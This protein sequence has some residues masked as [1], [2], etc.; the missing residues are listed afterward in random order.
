MSN[1]YVKKYDVGQIKLDLPYANYIHELPLLSFGDILHTINLSLVFNY[2]NRGENTFSVFKGYKFNWQK[3]IILDSSTQRPTSFVDEYGKTTNLY[4]NDG[5]YTF[6]DDSQRIIRTT[7]RPSLPPIPGSD[8]EMEDGIETFDYTVEYPDGSKEVYNQNGY[9]MS[10]CDKYSDN[11]FLTFLHLSNGRLS[12]IIYN[13]NKKIIFTYPDDSEITITYKVGSESICTTTINASDNDSSVLVD[14]YSGARYSISLSN[15]TYEVFSGD[16]NLEF[17]TNFSKKWVCTK[18]DNIL[19]IEKVVGNETVDSNEYC[20]V[21]N[22]GERKE[23]NLIDVTDKYNKTTRIQLIDGKPAYS[24]EYIDDFLNNEAYGESVYTGTVSSYSNTEII[25][26]QCENEGFSLH[27]MSEYSWNAPTGSLEGLSGVFILSGWINVASAENLEMTVEIEHSSSITTE[28]KRNIPVLEDQ[29][30]QYFSFPFEASNIRSLSVTSNPEWPTLY[31]KDVRLTFISGRIVGDDSIDYITRVEDVFIVEGVQEEVLPVSKCR[32]Y[33]GNT[34]IDGQVTKEDILRYKINQAYG[35]R[36]N[37]IY[38]NGCKN[39]I[40]DS[41]AF[42]M[43]YTND[44]VIQEAFVTNVA[45]GERCYKN[46]KIYLTKTN[47]YASDNTS[48]LMT[49]SYKD[50]ICYKTDIYSE[51]LDLISSKVDNI[52][53]TYSR[54]SKGL[55]CTQTVSA[56]GSTETI[57]TSASYNS[58]CTKLLSTTDEF[59]AT[60]TYEMDDIWG[61]ITKIIPDEDHCITNE[62]DLNGIALI[63]RT[64]ATGDGARNNSLGYSNGRLSSLA[65]GLLDYSF[66]YSD[67]HELQSII[68]DGQTIQTQSITENEEGSTLNVQYPSS[69]SETQTFDKYG[70]LTSIDGALNNTYDIAPTYNT[71]TNT[72]TTAGKDNIR[73]KLASTEDLTGSRFLRRTTKYAYE[74]N[75]LSRVGTFVT[76][77][78]IKEEIFTYDNADRMISDE[79]N[80]DKLGNKS[81]SSE[82]TY[83]TDQYS[84][85]VDNRVS[86]YKYKVNGVVKAQTENTYNPFKRIS[87]K[88]YW[89]NSSKYG[90]IYTFSGSR[91]S[92]ILD[93]F[94]DSSV[95]RPIGDISYEYDSIGR[96]S[97]INDNDYITNYTYDEYGQLIKEES[98]D[99]V[100]EY[101]YNGIG[102]IV[103]ATENGTATTFSYSNIYPDR[104]TEYGLSDITYNSSGYPTV[105]GSK[106]FDWSKGKLVKYYDE[107]DP[108]GSISSESTEFTYNGFGQRTSK[109]YT[110]N[111]GAD[112]SGD[113][114]TGKETKYEYDHS[115][116]LIR[117]ITTEYF[118]ESATQTR[119]FIFLYDESGMIG[120]MYSFNNS[121]PQAYYYQRNLLG[122]VIAIYNTSGNKVVEYAYD[123]YGNCTVTNSTNYALS[124]Y[125]PI[126]YRGY[127][128]DT[129]TGWYYLNARYYSP[130]WCRFISPDDTSYL[131]P[132]YVN[133]LNLYCYCGNDPVNYKQRHISSRGSATSSSISVGGSTGIGGSSGGSDSISNGSA[134]WYAQTIVGALP[135]LYSGARYLMTKGM[136]KY[137]A[138]KKNY[139]YMFPILGETH[140]RLAIH[141]TS[142]GKL[143]NATF[144]ELVTGNAKA[145]IGS[146]IGNI[147]GVG[148]FTFGTNLLFNLHEN[149]FDLTD[150]AMWI[151]TG[152][153]TAIG[154]GAYELAM[155]TASLATAGLAMAGVALPGIVVIGGVI[156]L[157][158][159][160]DHLIRAISGYW[161]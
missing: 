127:Y 149:G 135:D 64:F 104:L 161:E 19:T 44:D 14:H 8:I 35:E 5:I 121:T 115:G 103:S 88:Q 40:V 102:N 50:D 41:G 10:M 147:A 89:I 34:E 128:Y 119:E 24:Y 141:S 76:N 17:A 142:F 159:G 145:S 80:Y 47:F 105:Y 96:I 138:Y 18:I 108:T 156:I 53:T 84:P 78:A 92:T 66:V 99:K 29:T 2:A 28:I 46:G 51:F 60:T 65:C 1:T 67:K 152:I 107:E 39:L 21:N 146:V 148:V 87:S 153:D 93:T 52:T 136:H 75:R 114:T 57:T 12:S 134:P 124:L 98:V 55:V 122:D 97:S 13:N 116:R 106:H 32:F 140:K 151:D 118:T 144:R 54:N 77:N 143:S 25:G 132:E 6:G 155:G 123:A 30:W 16:Q 129:E 74:N 133:G 150:K 68:K 117:E 131:D 11:A 63:N 20:F 113:F 4:D 59:G 61:L 69:H 37:E 91:I 36:N 100:I 71:D 158:I 73:G 62:Y 58:S 15:N 101:V 22:L 23:Y 7:A 82:I 109:E 125:N 130:E 33:L 86:S 111:P 72:Y 126:K 120:F 70:R 94:Y 85:L 81:V 110:Y 56:E 31:W 137:F 42:T 3:R 154:M 90:Q 45:V 43:K 48:K 27:K 49:K 95:T 38:Y 139:Y 83:V 26:Y 157:S 9:L 79:C 160:F 112:Y